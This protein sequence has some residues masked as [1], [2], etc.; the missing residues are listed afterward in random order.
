MKQFFGPRSRLL[1]LLCFCLS[2]VSSGLIKPNPALAWN[3]SSNCDWYQP[4]CIA[5]KKINCRP[6]GSGAT[7]PFQNSYECVT[8]DA[9]S[10]WKRFN[11]SRGF[12]GV[13]SISGGWSVD[14]RNYAPVSASGHIGADAQALSPYNQYKYSQSYPFGALLLGNGRDY[15]SIQ[16]GSRF[17]SPLTAIDMRI[18][19]ADNALGDNSGSLRVCFE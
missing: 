16:Q 1:A 6:R 9:R 10:G 3:C 12:I 13:H 7:L 19:D 18:N 15:F 8:V 5:W 11:L 17:P 4:D 14:G 2:I